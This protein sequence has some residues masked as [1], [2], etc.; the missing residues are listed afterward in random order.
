M[1][2]AGILGIAAGVGLISMK[3]KDALADELT[4]WSDSFTRWDPLFRKYGSQYGVAPKYLKA[5]AMNE[6][7]L[8]EAPS[9]RR[10]LAAPTDI[11]GSK[12]SDGKSWG[13]MQLTLPTARDF[14]P[15]ATPTD[16]NNP[17][18]SV[19]VAAKFLARLQKR[20]PVVEVRWLEWVI[21]SYN[22]GE[23]NTEKER[24]GKA[25][26]YAGEYWARFLRNLALIEKKQGEL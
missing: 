5:I 6:S 22:Q 7:S 24:Q 16:L 15:N 19:R 8:G 10:G 14:E 21:K 25:S 23:G 20:F 2:L 12:S 3:T 4:A 9:V 1:N 18:F 11:E 13:L 17:D 26:G